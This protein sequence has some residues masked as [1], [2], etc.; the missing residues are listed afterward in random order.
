MERKFIAIW[1]GDVHKPAPRLFVHF[2]GVNAAL[3]EFGAGSS[4]FL[5]TSRIRSTDPG[6]ERSRERIIAARGPDL[7]ARAAIKLLKT[8][9]RKRV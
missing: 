1:V 6:S 7:V 4:A 2:A 5:I 8:R 9:L 3:E